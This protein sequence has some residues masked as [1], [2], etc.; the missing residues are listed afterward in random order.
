MAAVDS[1]IPKPKA[2]VVSLHVMNLEYTST[3]DEVN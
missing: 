3:E 2:L 1:A